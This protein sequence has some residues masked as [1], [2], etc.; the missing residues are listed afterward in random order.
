MNPRL[1][2]LAAALSIAF[3]APAQAQT[4]DLDPV[5]VSATRFSESDTNVAANVSVI[6]RDDIRNTPARDLPSMLKGSAGVGVRSLYGS[7]GIDSTIDIRGFGET[8]GSNTLILLDGQ[9]MN[10]IDMGSVSWSAIPLDSVQ[11]IEIMRGAGTVLYGDKATGGVVNI[12]TDKSGTPRFGATVG[13]GSYD[14]QTVDLN[15]A[16][17][18][19]TGYANAFARYA[20]TGGWRENSQAEQAALS[21]RGGLYVGKGEVFLDYALYNSMNGLPGPLLSAAYQANPKSA[22]S[23]YDSQR[24]DGY[25]VRPGVALPITDTLR[26]EAEV[27]YDKQDQHAN[28]V[29]FSSQADRTRD[30]WSVTPRLRW[31]HGLGGLKSETVA[32][33]DYYSGEVTA[34][35]S[36][37]AAQNAKQDS[38]GFYFQNITEWV[39][40]LSTTLGARSQRV[41]QSASQDAYSG[42]WGMQPAMSGNAEYTRSAW[43]LGLSYAGDGWRTYAK[44]G[45]TFRFANTDEL[46]GYDPFTGNPTFAGNLKPQTGTLGEIGGSFNAGPVTGRAA[47]Y[48]MNLEDEIAYDGALFSNVNLDKTRRQGLELE[49]DWRIVPSVLARLTYTYTDATFRE[50]MYDGKQIPLVP[51]NKASARLSWDGNALGTYTAVVNYV[52]QQY[53][54]G[55]FSNVQNKMSGYTTADFMAGW[56]FKP[57]SISARLLN[58]FDK[59]YSPYAGYSTFRSDYYYYPADGRTFLM[60]ASYNFR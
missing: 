51:H 21:G 36:S 58:A 43:D 32:G 6:T 41:D 5:I 22:S 1:T 34:T 2:P 14:T 23:P 38:T 50:G 47:L 52:G 53:Y 42:F 56:N 39:A 19:E 15:G 55:D 29:S 8:A 30:N 3:V 17:G 49:G 7:L 31:Q 40:G 10:P 11:R 9:R 45:T 27:S 57:W 44:G 28:Y 20:H 12:I 18:N 37:S 54:S 46:F 59:K 33:I 16:Y 13:I 25:R 48:R 26:F 60:T 24:S 35:Y 4:T